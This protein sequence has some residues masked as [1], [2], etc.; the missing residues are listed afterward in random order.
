M[1][2]WIDS[3]MGADDLF[4][5]LLVM[6]HRQVDGISLSFGNATLAQV[7]QNAV[8]AVGAFGW[9]VPI[10]AGADRAILGSV[11]TAEQ[12]HGTSGMRT[13]G[14]ALPVGKPAFAPA[15]PA[16]CTWLE[17]N[18]DCEV[19]ALGPLTN[20][21]TLALSRPDLLSRIRQIT[22]M[23]GG[24]TSGNHTPSAE[25]NAFADPEALAILLARNV[26][27]CMVDLDACR[28]VEITEADVSDVRASDHPQNE[29]LADLLGGYL[30]IALTRGRDTMALYD[31]V[32]AAALLRPELFTFSSAHIATELSGTHCRGRTIVDT[33]NP[34]QANGTVIS[35]L[36]SGNVRTLCL[37]A[38]KENR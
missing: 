32:A 19:L 37:S 17:S 5:I 16:L 21:A 35:G 20:L 36:D 29:L 7:E 31:P 15:L 18:E 2:I 10:W 6:Q 1:G 3:D 4:A 22:W 8:G 12:I 23:G 14:V 26:P 30:D 25:F 13:R 27:I 24:V 28:Q 33:R 38:L 11:E 9:T 34:D